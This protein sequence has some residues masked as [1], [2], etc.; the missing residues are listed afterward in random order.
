[1]LLF[2]GV[3]FV[4]AASGTFAQDAQPPQPDSKQFQEVV[5]TSSSRAQS[6]SQLSLST[7]ALGEMQVATSIATTVSGLLAQQGATYVSASSNQTAINI[8]SSGQ[9]RDFRGQVVFLNG[10][11]KATTNP[12]K[13]S[14]AD[15]ARVERLGGPDSL[16]Y[17]TQAIGSV[18]NLLNKDGGDLRIASGSWGLGDN[19]AQWGGSSGRVDYFASARA[20]QRSDFTVGAGRE[21]STNSAYEQKGGMVALG[22]A[23]STYDRVSMT[24]RSNGIFDSGLPG[25]WDFDSSDHRYKRTAEFAYTRSNP[26]RNQKVNAQLYLHDAANVQWASR[27]GVVDEENAIRVNTAY[28]FKG[29]ASLRLLPQNTLLIGVDTQKSQLR[30]NL[31]RFVIPGATTARGTSLD[32]SNTRNTGIYLE[33]THKLVGQRVQLRGGARVDIAERETLW[34]PLLAAPSE[35]YEAYTYRGGVTIR[36][37]RWWSMR[38]RI[39]TGYRAPS[40]AELTAD[41]ATPLS[42]PIIGNPYL[43]PDPSTALDAGRPFEYGRAWADVALSRSNNIQD[44]IATVAFEASRSRFASI[45]ESDV[46]ALQGQSRFELGTL[47]STKA[48]TWLGVNGV[49]NVVAPESDFQLLGPNAEQL[50]RIYKYQGALAFGLNNPSRWSLQ[51]LGTLYGDMWYGADGSL[52]VPEAN[53]VTNWIYNKSP[54]WV[55]GITGRKALNR[56]VAVTAGID[57]LFNQDEPATFFGLD[58]APVLSLPAAPKGNGLPG[59]S[60][61][62]GLELRP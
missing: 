18:M 45:A 15:L 42:N 12:S 27:E 14:L 25:S 46:T 39:G 4:G 44:R 26:Q 17:G 29:S 2:V 47:G 60:F 13:M 62:I 7:Q 3:L 32:S 53:S 19:L 16:M 50:D 57:N 58:K 34:G 38:A 9:D 22:Y 31:F 49:Y 1:M 20:T 40:A 28:G 56:G 6:V 30:N 37:T 33:D 59:R 54:F 55:V 43:R 52:L 24:L 21:A 5:S 61:T 36:P 11:R 41:F 10:N 35:S 48:R 51:L 23:A 8:G